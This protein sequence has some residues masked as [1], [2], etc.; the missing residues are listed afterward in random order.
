[1]REGGAD[2]AAIEVHHLC[3]LAAGEDNPPVEGVAALEVDETGALQRL[4]GVALIREMAPQISPGG[5][6]D[7]ELFDQSRVVHPTPFEVPQRLGMARELLL[8]EGCGS[9]QRVGSV[10][11]GALLLEISQALRKGEALG[12]LDKANQIAALSAA[13]AVEEILPG[14]DI[15]GRP[16]FKVQGTE[17]DELGARTC[18]SAAPVPL[19]QIIE[20]RKTLFQFFQILAQGGRLAFGDQRRRGPTL[21]PGK[22]GGG[23]KNSLRDGGARGLAEPESA[24]AELRDLPDCGASANEQGGRVSGAG[25]NE[26]VALGPGRGPSGGAWRDRG[27]DSGL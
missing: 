2:T 13:V 14:V 27:C 21:L 10:G 25:R 17:S 8:I 19:P 16:G 18:A 23:R 24:K 26:P 15:E 20:Q 12:Q 1:M 4:Q 9:L 3:V 7:A 11:W 22:D 5:I 6:A